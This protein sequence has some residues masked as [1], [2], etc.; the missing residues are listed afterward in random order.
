MHQYVMI[1][2][3]VLSIIKITKCKVIFSF[4]VI[5]I[6]EIFGTILYCVIRNKFEL[7]VF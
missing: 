1:K 3:C 4:N 5:G 7:C 6:T 2:T